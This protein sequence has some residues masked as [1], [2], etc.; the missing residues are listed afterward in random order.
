MG[1]FSPFIPAASQ[2]KASVFPLAWVDCYSLSLQIQAECS[3]APL[4]SEFVLGSWVN[5]EETQ[6]F[7][8]KTDAFSFEESLKELV[9]PLVHKVEHHWPQETVQKCYL[10]T[11]MKW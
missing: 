9:V 4:P 8:R 2:A 6:F 11:Q 10:H 1:G 3:W 7:H 5:T